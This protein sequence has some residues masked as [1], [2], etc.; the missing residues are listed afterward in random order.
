MVSCAG[1]LS[2]WFKQCAVFSSWLLEGV[3]SIEFTEECEP[4]IVPLLIWVLWVGG[5]TTVKIVKQE[6]LLCWTIQDGCPVIATSNPLKEWVD[7]LIHDVHH[8][9]QRQT[10]DI[11]KV[12][13]LKIISEDII[14]HLMKKLNGLWEAGWGIRMWTS[15]V[16]ASQ[17]LNIISRRE[18]SSLVIMLKNVCVC[19]NADP[20]ALLCTSG[21]CARRIDGVECGQ[22][23]IH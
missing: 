13:S 16:R 14:M 7:R 12:C 20:T 19:S 1:S 3:P 9:T 22:F 8:I 18:L 10:V 23:L 5:L 11:I 15:S 4:C 6:L 21:F 17:N 2:L